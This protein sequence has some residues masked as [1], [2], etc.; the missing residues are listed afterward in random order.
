LKRRLQGTNR[1]LSA[2]FIR[3]NQI[4]PV[5]GRLVQSQPFAGQQIPNPLG[6]SRGS[7]MRIILAKT[8]EDAAETQISNPTANFRRQVVHIIR[9]KATTHPEAHVFCLLLGI[10]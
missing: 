4:L 8:G 1:R 2:S 7:G 9:Q 5:A 6:L 3:R 10:I